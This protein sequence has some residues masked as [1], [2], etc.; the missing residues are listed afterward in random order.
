MRPEKPELA[1]W[2]E[3]LLR[4]N[5]RQT[6]ALM[7][8]VGIFIWMGLF[9]PWEQQ[10]MNELGDPFVRPAG[11]NF[12]LSPPDVTGHPNYRGSTVNWTQLLIQ[13]FIVGS[14][15]LVYVWRFRDH[16]HDEHPPRIRMDPYR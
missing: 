9:P 8:G 4:L 13:W 2:Q 6:R 12:I 10:F 1:P 14:A 15:T 5:V 3:R 16:L 11:F 7:L